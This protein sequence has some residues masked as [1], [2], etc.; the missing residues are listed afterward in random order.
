MMAMRGTLERMRAIDAA[1]NA[2]DWAA[3]G[4]LLAE[5]LTA[6]AGGEAEPHGK[7]AHIEKARKFC[8]IVADAHVWIEPYLDL[9]ASHDGSKSCSVARITGTVDGAPETFP[10]VALPP[11]RHAFDVT[12]AVVCRWQAGRIVEQRQLLDTALMLRQLQVHPR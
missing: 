7:H 11:G 5:G 3:Y 8:A 10:G 9:F 12:F 2:R 6:Y 4:D 1:W